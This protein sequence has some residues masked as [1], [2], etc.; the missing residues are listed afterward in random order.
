MVQLSF[1]YSIKELP[2]LFKVASKTHPLNKRSIVTDY[3]T[4]NLTVN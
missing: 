2:F 4:K 3:K 1:K